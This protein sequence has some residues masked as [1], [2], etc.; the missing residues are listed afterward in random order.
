MKRVNPVW[1]IGI[2]AAMITAFFLIAG[3][4]RK[5]ETAEAAKPAVDFPRRPIEMV[6]PFG[7]GSASDVFARQYA[8]ITE[9]YL[10]KP[11]NCVNKSGAGTIEGMTY[12]YNAPADGYTI[13]EITPSLLIK[14][15]MNDSDI[16]FRASFEPLIK[17]QND[18]QL[19]GVS[20]NSPHKTLE[21]LIAYAK[22]NPGKLKIGGV[23]PGGLDD[24]I[25]NGFA[26][27]AG[28]SWTYVPYKSGSEVK[29][30]VLGGELD[31]YQD[32]M[33]NFLPMAQS[34]DIIP[35]V[36]LSSK[37]YPNIPGL[38]KCPASVDKGI[39][40]T[41]GSWRGFVIKKGAPPEIKNILIDALKNAYADAAYKE[42]E[43]REMTNLN[44]GFMEAADWVKDWDREYNSLEEVFKQL[45]LI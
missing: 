42:M 2:V 30:A 5:G 13:L 7:S 4:A 33:I 12:A 25:A 17:V 21:D 38:E 29:A 35:L 27:A 32:K 1:V 24:Y 41:Q 20:K 45:G 34:G 31:V 6:I 16:K 22:A 40:F 9:K 15:L 36:V 18:L 3:C 10:G 44:P 19:F 14:E 43:E 23:S 28:F 8:Q 11:I 39:N 37:S 26:R